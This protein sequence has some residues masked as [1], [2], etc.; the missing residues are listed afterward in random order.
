MTRASIR[1]AGS[2]GS[3][4]V[5]TG[6]I[7]MNALKKHGF[8]L[9]SDREYPSLIK[10]GYANYTVDLDVKPVYSLSQNID[11][12]LAVDRI[13]LMN[14]IDEVKYGG[15]IVHDDDR[16]QLIPGMLEKVREKALSM[17]YI[18]ARKIAHE[19]GGN[20]L[21][22]NMVT[23]GLAWRI[24]GLPYEIL[25]AEVTKKFARKPQ[26]LEID[27]HC[28]HAGFEG[29][30]ASSLPILPLQ[31]P[32][33]VP[34]TILIEGNTSVC[35]GAIHAGVRAYYAYP[36]SPSSSI[37]S[38]MAKTS[39]QTGI[40]VKQGEDEITV[41]QMTLGSMFMGTRAFCATSGGGYDLM[42]ET[43]S[44]AAMIETPFV[45]VI[46]QRP[47]PA[48]GLPTWSSQGDLN[49]ALAGAHGEF[50]RVVIGLSDPESCFELIQH[51]F[52]IAEQYQVPV[53]VLS[54]KVVCETK[55]TVPPFRQNK[56]PIERGLVSEADKLKKLA[57]T[58][59]FRI[60][61]SGVSKRWLPGTSA[62]HYYA[63]S[64]E[65][66]EDGRIT[67]R[68]E[69][70]IPMVAKRMRKEKTLLKALPDPIIYGQGQDADVSFIGW[71][72]TKN[73]MLDTIAECKKRGV[74]VNYLHYDYVWPFKADNAQAFFANNKKVCLLEGN[75][76][77]QFGKLVENETHIRFFKKFLKFDGRQFFF[78]EVVGFVEEVNKID[79]S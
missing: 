56:I 73:V 62:A 32:E 50:P 29:T 5:I 33:T 19:N 43:V 39:H 21:M 72:S 27:L 25:A 54:E 1:I 2:S 13:G 70:I 10:G 47:G 44:L 22:T 15:I 46:C 36:M 58:D 40:V 68:A 16:Y 30:E 37:L 52:N 35:L 65:H 41:A 63:N 69:E 61:D 78:E 28:L 48:T 4:L 34:E 53:I 49:L 76:L 67:E 31:T 45:V 71:G 38:Y 7:M 77:G 12:V 3:G 9:N 57:S 20:E 24:M 8:Y 59:R 55:R 75:Y 6:A 14:G 79:L 60:T 18:P 17:A 23:L 66:R 64:D 11:L 51:G 42:T 26:H 74:S